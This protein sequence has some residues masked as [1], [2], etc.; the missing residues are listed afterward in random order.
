MTHFVA[1]LA[2]SVFHTA[3]PPLVAHGFD[4]KE[5]ATFVRGCLV[6]QSAKRDLC[7][8]Q[9]A[10]SPACIGSPLGSLVSARAELTPRIAEEEGPAFLGPQLTNRPCLDDFDQRWASALATPLLPQST[11]DTLTAS[12]NR[13]VPEPPPSLFQP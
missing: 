1:L 13:C 3:L 11:L 8:N 10:A 4:D 9:I 5:C 6:R 2:C 7:L 12:L